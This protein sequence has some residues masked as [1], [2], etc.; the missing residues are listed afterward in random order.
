[1]NHQ[2]PSFGLYIHWPYCLSKCPYCDFASVR[3]VANEPLLKAGYLR[4]IHQAPAGLLT[5]IYFGGGTPSLMSLPF[6]DF[7][8]NEIHKKWTLSPQA[9]IT[10]EVNPGAIEREKMVAFLAGGVN[11][12]SVGVQSLRENHLKFL[13]RRHDV[14]TAL[15]CVQDAQDIFPRVNMDL[16]YG[17]PHQSQKEWAQE[18]HQALQL[19]LTHYSLYQLTIEENTVFFHQ[20]QRG[21][22][23]LQGRAL[24]L[25]TDDIMNQAPCP[26]YEVSNYACPGQESRHNMLYW[27]GKDYIG[28]GPSACGRILGQATQNERTV[29]AWLK[30]PPT[31]EPLT[32]EQKRLEHL[33]MGLRL[34]RAFYPEASLNP[35]GIARA[36]QN[37][38]IER[39]PHGIRPTIQGTLMLNQLILLLAA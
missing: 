14:P 12:L 39:G 17:L 1:M 16:I 28:I 23:S 10:M 15:K 4:D 31:Y 27:T 25:L 8:M 5:S 20:R 11:R 36:L 24:Y 9:E 3:L 6:F 33:L 18:L 34:R 37:H 19:G 7:L 21:C 29:G 30:K 32:P 13:G 26:A 2:S 38:W 22:S 35:K